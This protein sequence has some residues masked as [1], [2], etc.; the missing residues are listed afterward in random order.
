MLRAIEW[1]LLGAGSAAAIV[2]GVSRYRPA[3]I[4]PWLL[5]AGSVVTLAVGDVFY[6]NGARGVADI[7]YY[8]MFVLVASSLLQLTR[9]G[10]ILVDRARLLDMLAFACSAL[11]VIWVFVIGSS[12]QIGQHLGRR[13]HR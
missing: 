12:G 11:L 9:G 7:C 2:F 8:G 3:R 6:A 10:A 13:R 1:I 5:L 4:G